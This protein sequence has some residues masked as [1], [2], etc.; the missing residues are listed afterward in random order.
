MVDAANE[1]LSIVQQCKLLNISRSSYYYKPS[2]ESDYNWSL[3]EIIDQEYIKYPFYGSRQMK[4]HLARKGY[5]ISRNRVRRLM[6][7][8]GIMAI[9]QNDVATIDWTEKLTYN[10]LK[11]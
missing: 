5:H 1:N 3:M 2:L 7:K 9:Y 6:R 8:M 4:R 11:S 10:Y